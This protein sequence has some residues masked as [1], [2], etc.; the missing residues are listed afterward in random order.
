MRHSTGDNVF[1]TKKKR[2]NIDLNPTACKIKSKNRYKKG[3]FDQNMT[4]L[5][6]IKHC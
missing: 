6:K 3:N 1:V 2:N 4:K 5:R